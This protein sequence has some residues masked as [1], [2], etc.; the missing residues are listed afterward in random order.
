MAA[1][2]WSLLSAFVEAESAA[3]VIAPPALRS[4]SVE[5]VDVLS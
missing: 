5:F 3:K 2:P 4:S 1:A